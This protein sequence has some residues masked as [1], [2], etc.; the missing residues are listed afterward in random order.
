MKYVISCMLL[1][2]LCFTACGE[3][4]ASSLPESSSP[5]PEA[6][7]TRV[8]ST[9]VEEAMTTALP[10]G[11][12]LDAP[13][14]SLLEPEAPPDS[15]QEV[16]DYT[17]KAVIA[18][19]VSCS[20]DHLEYNASDDQYLWRSVGYLAGQIGVDQNLL[21]SQGDFGQITPETA[22]MLAYAVNGDFNGTLPVVTEEDPL[23]SRAENGD[24]LINLLS[25]GTL[26]LQMTEN[27]HPGETVTEEAELFQNGESLGRYSVTL[28]DYRGDITGGQYFSYSILDVTPLP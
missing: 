11:S 19:I 8:D 20:L 13:D 24:Y 17:E 2:V 10:E 16:Q 25:Q 28:T 18:A 1:M 26:E 7:G 5:A 15:T 4:Q 23:I 12:I 22:A 3:N 9:P 6:F 21:T 14:G 27:R